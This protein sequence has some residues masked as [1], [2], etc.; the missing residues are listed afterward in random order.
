MIEHGDQNRKRTKVDRN[1]TRQS[2]ERVKR[3]IIDKSELN[4]SMPIIPNLLKIWRDYSVVDM[5]LE[6]C[7]DDGAVRRPS[8]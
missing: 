7:R 2:R 5:S 8:F 3:D 4:I 6:H 1:H